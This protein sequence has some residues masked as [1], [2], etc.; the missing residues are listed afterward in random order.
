MKKITI[1]A[2]TDMNIPKMNVGFL[3]TLKASPLFLLFIDFL[4]YIMIFNNYK[5]RQSLQEHKL[6]FG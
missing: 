4:Y 3:K 5:R 2:I 6:D 1:L